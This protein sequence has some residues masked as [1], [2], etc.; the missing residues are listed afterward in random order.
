MTPRYTNNIAKL[1]VPGCRFAFL[2]EAALAP[3][4][5]HRNL[6]GSEWLAGDD[7]ESVLRI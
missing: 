6:V 3:I 1:F 7:F 5:S 4:K 2:R